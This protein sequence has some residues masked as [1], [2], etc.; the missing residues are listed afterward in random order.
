MEQEQNKQEIKEEQKTIK[1]PDGKVLAV[2]A[3]LGVLIIVPFLVAKDDDFV[4]FHLRQG[5]TLIILIWLFILGSFTLSFFFVLISDLVIFINSVMLLFIFLLN[6]N[7][8]IN[9]IGG[10]KKELPFVGLL[11]KKLDN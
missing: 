11:A 1:L 3:Y 4:S 7:G 8:I 2:L 9:V 5:V 10:Q 6:M